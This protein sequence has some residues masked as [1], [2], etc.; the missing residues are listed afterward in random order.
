[1]P[2]SQFHI[3]CTAPGQKVPYLMCVSC[4]SRT[5]G[6]WALW[7]L[8]LRLGRAGGMLAIRQL[9]HIFVLWAL[10]ATGDGYFVVARPLIERLF[11]EIECR[12]RGYIQKAIV[13]GHNFL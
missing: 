8:L 7:A 3:C 10:A 6:G 4:G 11:V 12:R 1:M 9:K 5:A 2:L 13:G